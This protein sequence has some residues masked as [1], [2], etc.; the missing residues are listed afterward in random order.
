M[1]ILP[2]TFDSILLL[3]HSCL[4]M[5]DIYHVVY[6]IPTTCYLLSSFR[7]KRQKENWYL[8][9][10]DGIIAMVDA[11]VSSFRFQHGAAEGRQINISLI[12]IYSVGQAWVWLLAHGA[13]AI[14]GVTS[15]L[16]DAIGCRF[17][18]NGS[19]HSPCSVH[20]LLGSRVYKVETLT[21]RILAVS[22]IE[23]KFSIVP[24]PL[25]KH[26]V[27]KISEN[28]LF[29]RDHL[30]EDSLSAWFTAGLADSQ[31]LKDLIIHFF[32]APSP[33][34]GASAALSSTKALISADMVLPT[35]TQ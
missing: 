13:P 24:P 27:W 30:L 11:A 5:L 28:D 15:S 20:I 31:V 25:F 33:L 3:Y 21:L 8:N 2:D 16:A 12:S 4:K 29:F 34:I 19:L 14:V 1:I 35:A 6:I 23:S 7:Q 17:L 26:G 18:V 32:C 10:P 22:G 9:A